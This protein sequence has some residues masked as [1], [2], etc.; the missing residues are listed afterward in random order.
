MWVLPAVSLVAGI[1]AWTLA[2]LGSRFARTPGWRDHRW[3]GLVAGSAG[4][5]CL[6]DIVVTLDAPDW[7]VSLGSRGNWCALAVQ[8]VAWILHSSAHLKTPVDRPRRVLVLLSA[9]LAV[10]A[11]IPGTI[12]TPEVTHHLWMGVRYAEALPGPL[13]VPAGIVLETAF[14]FAMV[15]YVRALRTSADAPWY[16]ASMVILFVASLNDAFAATGAYGLPYVLDWAFLPTITMMGFVL[17]RR[18]V[19]GARRLDALSTD[20]EA[21]VAART[22]ELG[23]VN[24][25]LVSAERLAAIG[26]LSA[27]VAH[28][29]NNPAAAVVANL[30]YLESIVKRGTIPADATETL[31][32]TL[33]SMEK[34]ARIVRQ[35]LDTGRIAG[36]DASPLST[37][38]VARVARS[39][40]RLATTS[41]NLVA[42]VVVH[43]EEDIHA[44]ADAGALEQ[45]FVNLIVNGMQAVPD[46]RPRKVEIRAEKVGGKVLVSVEDNGSGMSAET[47]HRVFEPFFTT[48]PFGK[49]TGLGLSV[50]LGLARALGGDLSIGQTS[51]QG[52]T[53]IL[54]L[55]EAT[56]KKTGP[57]QSITRIGTRKRVLVVDDERPVRDALRRMLS[58]SFEVDIAS[59]GQEALD[60]IAQ[61]SFDVILCDLMMASGGGEVLFAKLQAA[62][63]ELASRLIFVTGGATDEPSKAFL[64]RQTQP[65]LYKPV[66]PAS[67]IAKID[68]MV[69]G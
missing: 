51:D 26:R 42:I 58:R 16:L 59:G 36:A 4:L 6:C 69:K 48:K 55:V 44:I 61:E 47:R 60:K 27:G 5:Y 2:F 33:V 56:S 57:A 67:L 25:A 40:M 23:E 11:W 34:I 15:T 45:I 9:L 38:H 64:A 10:V 43:I 18:F 17:V 7:V 53:M 49:G 29:I 32:D 3:F 21:M 39:A 41:T 14:L 24:S 28:E 37:V 68:Q 66:D 22:R 31:Q 35:L 19:E 13:N 20:L 30:K 65:V 50:S 8:G 1:L 63:P 46:G 54:E 52:T 62:C 12:V